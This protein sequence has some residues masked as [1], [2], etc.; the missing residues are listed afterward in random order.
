MAVMVRFGLSKFIHGPPAEGLRRL[1]LRLRF[2]LP[3]QLRVP[4]LP[5]VPKPEGR[6]ECRGESGSRSASGDALHWLAT[7]ALDAAQAPETQLLCTIR[8]T[9]VRG[10]ILALSAEIRKKLANGV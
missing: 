4:F 5:G 7:D 1:G 8:F 9:I 6:T 3:R 2:R 10:V